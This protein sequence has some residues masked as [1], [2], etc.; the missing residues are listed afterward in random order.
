MSQFRFIYGID[1]STRTTSA[2]IIAV[3][4]E[5]MYNDDLTSME[6]TLL[7]Q[8]NKIRKMKVEREELAP[9]YDQPQGTVIQFNMS[10]DHGIEYRYCGVRFGDD[11]IW[12]LTGS[13]NKNRMTT[14]E[15]IQF[16]GRATIV[17]LIGN[18]HGHILRDRNNPGTSD[19]SEAQT[20]NAVADHGQDGTHY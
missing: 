15:L 10:W 7:E 16:L 3:R 17:R 2:A 9:L 13:R 4:E 11:N 5:N 14:E 12:A 19:V 1:P 6:M 18:Q 8:L 20:V